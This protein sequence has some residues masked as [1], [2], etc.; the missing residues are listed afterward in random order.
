MGSY[1]PAGTRLFLTSDTFEIGTG[2][3]QTVRTGCVKAKLE[4]CQRHWL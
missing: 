1:L 3:S 4:I 2:I